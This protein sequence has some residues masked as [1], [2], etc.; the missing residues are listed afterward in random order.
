MKFTFIP[1]HTG[2]QLTVYLTLESISEEE[3]EHEIEYIEDSE[4]NEVN[5]ENLHKED[6]LELNKKAEEV[7]SENAYDA[8]FNDQ[9]FTAEYYAD[10]ERER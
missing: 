5:F 8:F 9:M 2:S 1:K 4:G 3:C 7:A 10:L 6:I